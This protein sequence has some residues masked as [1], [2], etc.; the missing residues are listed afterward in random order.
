[1]CRHRHN[2]LALQIRRMKS[3]KLTFMAQYIMAAQS[4]YQAP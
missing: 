1:M 2:Q 4:L 3:V